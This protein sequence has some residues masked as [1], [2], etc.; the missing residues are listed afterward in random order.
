MTS[1]QDGDYKMSIYMDEGNNGNVGELTCYKSA[2][3]QDGKIQIIQ[4]R[5]N[6]GPPSV[7]FNITKNTGS[8]D[9][10]T[11]KFKKDYT[12]KG[13]DRCIGGHFGE[14]NPEWENLWKNATLENVTACGNNAYRIKEP[15]GNV[16]VSGPKKD[17]S[18]DNNIVTIPYNSSLDKKAGFPNDLTDCFILERMNGPNPI[19]SPSPNPNPSPSPNPNP[20]PS[21]NPNPSPSPSPSGSMKKS[22][23]S[24]LFIILGVGGGVL[25]IILIIFLVMRFK[26]KK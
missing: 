13:M 26:T 21:P 10:Y 15:S 2:T 23:N 7:L 17:A 19:P 14:G 11:V 25:L 4:T 20:S 18:G 3:S 12:L 6:Q 24:T 5:N 16:L 1:L 9:T 8:E 22:S